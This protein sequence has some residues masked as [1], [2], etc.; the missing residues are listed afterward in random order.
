[1]CPIRFLV[2]YTTTLW[3]AFG[4]SLLFWGAKLGVDFYHPSL[5]QG[6]LRG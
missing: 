1:M 5:V 4:P 2:S 6:D 3:G